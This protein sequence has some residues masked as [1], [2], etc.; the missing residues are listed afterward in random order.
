MS[1]PTWILPGAPF[2]AMALASVLSRRTH[3]RMYTIV[4]KFVPGGSIATVYSGEDPIYRAHDTNEFEAML[5]AQQWI[6][7][8][9]EC[10]PEY[11]LHVEQSVAA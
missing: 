2:G 11:D 10:A 8:R 3:Y 1:I 6:D 4:S 9:E 5:R 7:E